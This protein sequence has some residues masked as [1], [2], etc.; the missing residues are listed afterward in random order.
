MPE[1]RTLVANL[2]PS[3]KDEDMRKLVEEIS[4]GFNSTLTIDAKMGGNNASNPNGTPQSKSDDEMAKSVEEV[5]KAVEDANKILDEV[6]DSVDGVED[7]IEKVKDEVEDTNTN[8]ED[9]EE[10]S[11][12]RL[13]R[14]FK[15]IGN[16]KEAF[17]DAMESFKENPGKAI[18]G[19]FGVV[20]MI[21]DMFKKLFDRLVSSSP[22]LRNI[23]DLFN[24]ALNLIIGPLGTAIGMELIPILTNMYDRIMKG[25]QAIWKAYEEGGLKG[26]IKET[27]NV[28]WDVFA[29]LIP[30]LTEMGLY[31][32]G[33]FIEAIGEHIFDWIVDSL[34]RWWDETVMGTFDS[35]GE[36]IG[37]AVSGDFSGLFNNIFGF[38]GGGKNTIPFFDE[39]GIVEAN[40]PYGTLAVIGESEREYIIPQS[41]ISSFS[42]SS[43]ST[44]GGTTNNYWY[45][46]GYTDA[47]LT[48]KIIE[49]VD[50]RTDMSRLSGGI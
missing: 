43:S 18:M 45:I 37:D 33:Q 25:V 4:N 34:T 50:K 42:Q 21:F 7:G 9:K 13:D 10:K 3:V 29:P 12:S 6:L 20:L 47:T 24:N 32:V 26:M 49:V 2:V 31:I 40:P 28:L 19:A 48:D 23:L 46:N 27:F 41:K 11:K 16:P 30:E 36:S 15:A 1:E 39:G 14:L 5:K 17:G 44:V 38:I 8:A 35:I 22:F